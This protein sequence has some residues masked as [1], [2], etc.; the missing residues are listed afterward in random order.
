MNE[1]REFG[2]EEEGQEVA[3]KEVRERRNENKEAAENGN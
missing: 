1:W 2:V 3:E